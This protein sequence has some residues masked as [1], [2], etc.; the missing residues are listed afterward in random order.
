M[1]VLV[2][3]RMYSGVFLYVLVQR[4]CMRVCVCVFTLLHVLWQFFSLARFGKC[5]IAETVPKMM[6]VYKVVNIA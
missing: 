3:L 6:T 5:V 1:N 2:S 4:G